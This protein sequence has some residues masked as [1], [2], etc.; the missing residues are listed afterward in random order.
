[1]LLQLSQTFAQTGD[2]LRMQNAPKHAVG[3]SSQHKIN[4][5]PFIIPVALTAT[6]IYYTYHTGLIDRYAVRDW[7]NENYPDFH[8]HADDYLQF[9]PAAAVYVLD[10]TGMK[11]RN[12]VRTQTIKLLE[13]ELIMGIL[14]YSLKNT[15][16]VERP[17]GSADNSFPSGHTE[18]AFVSATFLHKEFG[19]GRPWI[20]IAGY[21]VATSVGLLRVLNNR[22]WITDVI[23]GAGMGMLSVELAYLPLFQPGKKSKHKPAN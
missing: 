14:V 1:M 17:D 6:G 3:F 2:S 23:A 19:K 16:S 11:A 20:S 10:L 22:H 9:V 7:R 4:L 21:A 12:D 15:T 5:R 13:S 18:Q 8:T